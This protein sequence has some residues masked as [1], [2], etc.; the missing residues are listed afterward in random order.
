MV[1]LRHAI[2][3][4]KKVGERPYLQYRRNIFTETRSEGIDVRSKI[5]N[6]I[7]LAERFPDFSEDRVEKRAR[8]AV[9]LTERGQKKVVAVRAL[10]TRTL[11]RPETGKAEDEHR[12]EEGS[13]RRSRGRRFGRSHGGRSLFV[14]GR[15][16]RLRRAGL[17]EGG[18]R[19]ARIFDAPRSSCQMSLPQKKA[20]IAVCSFLLPLAARSFRSSAPRSLLK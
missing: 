5:V 1:S 4:R 9:R 15:S 11:A 3:V 14:R 2:E 13:T 20:V 18:R 10:E 6:L 12:C 8:R 7:F 17:G 16:R 19:R